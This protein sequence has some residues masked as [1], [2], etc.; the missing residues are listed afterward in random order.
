MVALRKP[1]R[2]FGLAKRDA[3]RIDNR[4]CLR[5]ARGL[6]EHFRVRVVEADSAGNV[7]ARRHRGNRDEFGQVD[8]LREVD[9]R[10][11]RQHLDDC[12]VPPLQLQRQNVDGITQEIAVRIG[13][14]D[15][16]CPALRR[17]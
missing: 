4:R 3:V 16:Y 12:A 7:V 1:D 8:I 17:R 2:Q 15:H 11:V 10:A 6:D 13:E 5:R 9:P 14:A